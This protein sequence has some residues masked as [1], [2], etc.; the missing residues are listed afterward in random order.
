MLIMF[1]ENGRIRVETRHKS[2]LPLVRKENLQLLVAPL[3]LFL[4]SLGVANFGLGLI[5]VH[6]ASVIGEPALL[7]LVR[8]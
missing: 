4:A 6:V 8:I 7:Q 1:A 3:L 5:L 2:V